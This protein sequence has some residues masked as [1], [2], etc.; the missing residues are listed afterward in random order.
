MDLFGFGFHVGGINVLLRVLKA[1]V[2]SMNFSKDTTTRTSN[3]FSI[4]CIAFILIFVP[5]LLLVHWY[6]TYFTI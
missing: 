6:S 3:L 4:S 5:L 1:C 2:H